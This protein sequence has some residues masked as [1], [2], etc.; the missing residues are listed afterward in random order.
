MEITDYIKYVPIMLSFLILCQSARKNVKDIG[1]AKIAT[2]IIFWGF[3]FMFINGFLIYDDNLEL[4]RKEKKNK[5]LRK[6]IQELNAKLDSQGYQI[7]SLSKKTETI[8]RSSTAI[9]S[10]FLNFVVDRGEIPIQGK[11]RKGTRIKITSGNCDNN[12]VLMH[13]N[14]SYP[15]KDGKGECEIIFDKDGQENRTYFSNNGRAAC[16]MMVEIFSSVDQ[17]IDSNKIK[18]ITD[19]ADKT[20]LNPLR[21]ICDISG[22]SLEG[23]WELIEKYSECNGIKYD[24]TLNV[25]FRVE[26]FLID[27]SNKYQIIGYKYGEELENNK[28]KYY[29]KKTSIHLK[30]G[31]LINEVYDQ[32]K[33]K[34]SLEIPISGSGAISFDDVEYRENSIF[35]RGTFTN[36]NHKCRGFVTMM[37]IDDSENDSD[38][39]MVEE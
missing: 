32:E 37:K 13:N 19:V 26:K 5:K 22:I 15:I 2:S 12:V 1:N 24:N 38:V 25:Y 21:S 23:K 20:H 35:L 29:E 7:D 9:V 4:I 16:G 30:G 39:I 3:I 8:K 14:R 17:T 36:S 11:I 10:K 34:C 27:K 6:E 31:R 28:F 33:E 18:I